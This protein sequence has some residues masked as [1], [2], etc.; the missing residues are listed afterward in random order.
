[1]QCPLNARKDLPMVSLKT[2]LEKLEAQQQL[3]GVDG[4]Q[5]LEQKINAATCDNERS[6]FQKVLEIVRELEPRPV[7][8]PSS[9]PPDLICFNGVDMELKATHRWQFVIG[10]SFDSSLYQQKQEDG[11][12]TPWQ[13]SEEMH[14]T[15]EPAA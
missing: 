2:R 10:L 13:T 7:F 4:I 11:T 5:W 6:Y 9:T 14:S 8:R 15:A 12:W 3:N 1:M